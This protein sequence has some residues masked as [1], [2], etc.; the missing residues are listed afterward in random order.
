MPKKK[1]IKIASQMELWRTDALIPYTFNAKRHPDHQISLIM[2]SIEEYGFNAPI[3]VDRGSREIVAGHGRLIAALNLKMPE[4]PV[5]VVDH[6]TK[7]Q[8]RAY[9]LADNKLGELGRWDDSLLEHELEHL[10]SEAEVDLTKLGFS[11]AELEDILGLDEP[12]PAEQREEIP[13]QD[14]EEAEQEEEIPEHEPS[15]QE[16]RPITYAHKCPM[17]SYEWDDQ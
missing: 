15:E 14:D 6:M 5:V 8:R 4:V 9:I 17:C 16:D 3:L 7:D 12:G 10:L 1:P 11:V 13:E 2:K